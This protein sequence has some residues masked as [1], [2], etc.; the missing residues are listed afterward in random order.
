[1]PYDEPADLI[2]SCEATLDTLGLLLGDLS[3][4]VAE[5][6]GDWSIAQI[7]NHLLD[8]ENRYIGRVRRMRRED[9]PAMRMMPDPDY[10]KLSAL[11]AWT[12][13]YELRKRHLK[14][15]RSLEP[16][17]WRRSGTLGSVGRVSIAGLVR[18][19][20]AHDATHV[21]QIARRLS[22]RPG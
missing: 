15:L 2:G 13:F 11:K 12:R 22:G 10:T 4:E 20:A 1:M 16:A 14:L 17:E 5:S 8:T 7:L 6:P 19:M 9:R 21:A 18:H 3:E